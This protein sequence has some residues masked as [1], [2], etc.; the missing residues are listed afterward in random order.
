MRNDSNGLSGIDASDDLP[1]SEMVQA[2]P[3]AAAE[4]DIYLATRGGSAHQISRFVNCLRARFQQVDFL[5]P[6]FCMSAG[7]LFALSGDHIW[8]TARACLGPIDPQVP[9]VDGRYVPA[10]ALLLL[11]QQLR[12]QGD[13]AMRRGQPVPWT[14]VRVIDTL[15]KKELAEAITASDYSRTMA[16]QFLQSYKFRHWRV[17]ESSRQEVTAEYRENRADTIAAALVSHER[18]KSH[19]HAIPRHVLWQ[20]IQLR[21]DEP[22]PD[23]ERAMV[24]LWALLNWV[25]D[26]TNVLKFITSAN[27]RYVRH[28][29]REEKQP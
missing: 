11:V 8:M 14:A 25:F 1:F 15:D 23:L 24:R 29:V 4:V 13:E 6:S 26:K 12:Q 22:A 7:T 3:R 19:G 28:E 16:S 18:W 9:T 21:I 2:G 27:Y 20:E 5:V 17:R 10:Q